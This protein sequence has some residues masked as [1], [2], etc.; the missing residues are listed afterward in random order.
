MSS[1]SGVREGGTYSDLVCDGVL[2]PRYPYT[3]GSDRGSGL[4][5]A[6]EERRKGGRP[7][8]EVTGRARR[9]PLPSEV[10]SSADVGLWTPVPSD[11]TDTSVYG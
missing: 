9:C 5:G 8:N 4:D 1:T 2:S 3:R 6:G 7:Y 11:T 10:L